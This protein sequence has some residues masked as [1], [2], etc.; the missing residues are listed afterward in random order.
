MGIPGD[1]TRIELVARKRRA[2]SAARAVVRNQD[3]RPLVKAYVD[4]PDWP[5]WN[6]VMGAEVTRLPAEEKGGQTERWLMEVCSPSLARFCRENP[7][8]NFLHEF[9]ERTLVNIDRPD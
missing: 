9:L 2:D 7:G 5:V 8:R 4:F 3:F 1:Y 6:S